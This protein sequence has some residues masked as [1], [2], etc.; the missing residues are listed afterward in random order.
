MKILI[1]NQPLNNRGDESAHK[2]LVRTIL[3]QVEG[4][5]IRV[6]FGATNVDSIKQFAV[7]SKKVEYINEKGVFP[8]FWGYFVKLCQCLNTLYFCNLHPNFKQIMKHY[9]WADVIVCAPGGICM[10]GFQ[11]WSHLFYLQLAKYIHKP[12]AYYGRS[13]G[14]FP[15]A[16][17]KNRKFKSISIQMLRYFTYLSIRDK[18]TEKLAKELSLSYIHTVDSAF[19]DSPQV[20]IPKEICSVIGNGDYFV[21]VPNLLIWHYTYKS[22]ITKEELLKFYSDLI[23]HIFHLHPDY[24]AVLLPQTFN[25]D[26]EE[27]D[28]VNFFREFATYKNDHRIIVIDDIYSSDIQQAIIASSKLVIGAR[29]H[30]VV[31]ALN[32]AVPFI[33]LSYEHKISGLLETLGKTDCMVDIQNSIFTKNGRE[34]I[35]REFR[36]K[37]H[38]LYSD[39]KAKEKAKRM[40]QF[41]FNRFKTWIH[42][43]QA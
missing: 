18:K 28:D 36:E 1:V 29:Y 39:I 4:A 8:H 23:D 17:W 30:S 16:T 10:G 41:A 19:L 20:Q 6:L 31:F 26:S 34:Q 32:N 11:N 22:K 13:F 38:Q 43:Y 14:P 40:S 7:Q 2:G 5:N 33:A 42:T 9:Q 25:S 27:G 35:N 3:S 15:V 37:S 12:L 24:K 21:Y